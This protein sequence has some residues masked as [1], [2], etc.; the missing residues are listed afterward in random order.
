MIR[1]FAAA[2]AALSLIAGCTAKNEPVDTDKAFAAHLPW[3][4][5][6]PGVQKD[7]SGLQW[8]VLKKGDG[9]TSPGATDLV[10]VHYEGRTAEGEKFDSSFDRG[11]PAMF[12][13]NQVI[14]GWTIGLQK[15]H[16]G[17][18][19]LFYVPN[20]LAYG[21]SDRGPVIKAGDDL[22]FLVDLVSVME[23][24]STD[25]AAWTKYTP[26]NSAL[27]EVKKTESGLEYVVLASGDPK[28]ESPVNGEDVVVYYEG[29]LAENG[30]MFD[31][32]Y[33]RGAPE[34]FPSDQLIPGWVE[35]LSMMKP[36]DRW[37]LYIPS[38]LAYGERGTPGGP[39]PPNADLMFEVEMVDVLKKP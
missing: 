1:T 25:S 2:L 36:G 34:I 31:S 15:M 11:Q 22:V 19:F 18:E 8:V 7:E 38:K 29:R 30:E 32:A 16:E 17:D 28:G 33:Q 37:M 35:A 26:W 9:K 24:K 39:I 12:R 20:K 10:R 5:D 13:L 4:P 14:P 27:P 3:K 23:P 6:A 21:N